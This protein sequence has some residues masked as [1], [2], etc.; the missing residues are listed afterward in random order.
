MNRGVR[1]SLRWLHILL[2]GL[3]I[4]TYLYSPWGSVAAFRGIVLWVVFPTL[5]ITGLVLWQWARIARLLYGR[6]R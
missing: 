2:G 6:A 3:I 5:A 4:G 1:N